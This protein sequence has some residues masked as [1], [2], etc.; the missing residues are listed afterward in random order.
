MNRVAQILPRKRPDL[1]I[2]TQRISH[3]GGAHLAHK[4]LLE[5][6]AHLSDDDKALRGDAALS[7]IHEPSLGADF[8][9]EIEVGIIEDE[10]RIAAAKLQHG[11]L[12]QRAGFACH[13]SA[14]WPASC[15]CRGADQR[16][17]DHRVHRT[18]ADHQRAKEILGE[19]GFAE[20]LFD[21]KRHNQAHSRRA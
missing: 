17:L 14:S 11:L 20:D 3:F 13:G 10:V 5:L 9:G 19:A 18:A 4:E 21:R 15:Q 16:M 12:Q 2:V 7:R 1:R 6:P 8:R